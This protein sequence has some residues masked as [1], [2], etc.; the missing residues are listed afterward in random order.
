MPLQ[1]SGSS[2][3]NWGMNIFRVCEHLGNYYKYKASPVLDEKSMIFI[4][5][6]NDRM[7]TQLEVNKP[8]FIPVRTLTQCPGFF[9]YLQIFHC[10]YV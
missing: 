2:S 5:G 8:W 10:P 3:S 4:I 1:T 6:Y 9:T 7:A